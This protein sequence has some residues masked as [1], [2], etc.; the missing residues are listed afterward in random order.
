MGGYMNSGKTFEISPRSATIKELK[1][2]VEA[3]TIIVRL[4]RS[5]AR[6]TGERRRRLA[7]VQD[8]RGTVR[9]LCR[10]RPRLDA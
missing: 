1:K 10:M 4:Q 7:T 8:L 5:L 2:K 6:E 9:V 3:E